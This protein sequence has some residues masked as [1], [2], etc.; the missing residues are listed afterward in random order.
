VL[1]LFRSGG[2]PAFSMAHARVVDVVSRHVAL[3]MR[4]AA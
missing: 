1:S 3:A 2:T 4:R